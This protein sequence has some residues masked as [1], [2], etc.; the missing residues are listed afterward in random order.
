MGA[1]SET[2]RGAG[3]GGQPAL[4][5]EELTGCAVTEPRQAQ[6]HVTLADTY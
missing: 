2:G 6:G 1:V 5:S 3:A 4:G